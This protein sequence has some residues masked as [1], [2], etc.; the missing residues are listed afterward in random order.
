MGIKKG[1]KKRWQTLYNNLISHSGEIK[2]RR[3][4]NSSIPIATLPPEIILN[5]ISLT[6]PSVWDSYPDAS[7]NIRICSQVCHSWRSLCL[8]NPLLWSACFSWLDL[9]SEKWT[10]ELLR[11]S[12]IDSPLSVDLWLSNKPRSESGSKRYTE[13]SKTNIDLL[14]Q[15]HEQ[16]RHLQICVDHDYPLKDFEKAFL[17]FRGSAPAL[18]SFTLLMGDRSYTQGYYFMLDPS[19]FG[20]KAC[21]L[22]HLTLRNCALDFKSPLYCQLTS[23]DIFYIGG[24]PRAPTAAEWLAV[25]ETCKCLFSLSLEG[26]ISSPKSTADLHEVSLPSLAYLRLHLYFPD[27]ITLLSHLRF[28]SLRRFDVI[29]GGIHPKSDEFQTLSN[30]LKFHIDTFL[31][32]LK[33]SSWLLSFLDNDSIRVIKVA[34][35]A[36]TAFSIQYGIWPDIHLSEMPLAISSL[37][38]MLVR[39]P[40]GIAQTDDLTVYINHPI[41]PK[42]PANDRLLAA[43]SPFASV[44]TLRLAY[45]K[46]NTRFFAARDSFW[47]PRCPDL[48]E[49]IL[50]YSNSLLTTPSPLCLLPRLSR[51]IVQPTTPFDTLKTFITQR[52]EVGL[53][54]QT[55]HFSDYDGDVVYK[56]SEL[57]SE[58]QYEQLRKLGPTISIDK[59]IQEILATTNTV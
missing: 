43:L 18:S 37:L 26:Y 13:S 9:L 20:G 52:K 3:N 11:R 59:D 38:S 4:H 57:L 14:S 27:A 42:I 2:R 1:Y 34:P 33:P 5:I 31:P 49:N 8:S 47:R 39:I 29:V 22:K 53:P 15:R 23:L 44:T 54:I 55:V 19:V 50:D 21:P 56:R 30:I 46:A 51:L 28:S 58:A 35:G 6:G 16:I 45:Y 41:R 48:T 17:P 7:K 36:R 25:I 12:G 32:T 40:N 10:H 24:D